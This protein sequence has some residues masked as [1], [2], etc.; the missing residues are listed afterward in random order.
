[1][2]GLGRLGRLGWPPLAKA[3][4]AWLATGARLAWPAI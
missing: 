4:L 2:T 1:M 3:V